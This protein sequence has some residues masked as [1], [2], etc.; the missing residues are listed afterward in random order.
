MVSNGGGFIVLFNEYYYIFE[1][2]VGMM[3]LVMGGVWSGKSCYVE[4]FIG[5]FL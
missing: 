5:D 3:I 4:V 1:L 2:G